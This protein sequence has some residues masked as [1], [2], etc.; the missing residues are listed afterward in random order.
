MKCRANTSDHN[1]AN[2]KSD[3]DKMKHPQKEK[4]HASN[5][6]LTRLFLSFNNG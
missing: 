6:L 4:A 3:W 2:A 1:A 5:F